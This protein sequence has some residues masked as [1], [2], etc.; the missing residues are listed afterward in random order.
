MTE[1][2]DLSLFV[3][4][5]ADGISHM[6]LAVEGVGCA[7]CIRKIENGL[8]ELPG[9]TEARL[10]FTNRRLAVGWRDKA[11]DAAEVI[12]ALDRI[13]YRAHPFEAGRAESDEARQAR[14]L[15]RCLAVAGFAAMNIMLLSVAVWSGSS[16]MTPETRDFFHWLSALIALPAAAY[17]GQPFFRSAGM[18]CATGSANMDVP[19][20]L[21]VLLALGMSVIETINHAQ[22]AYFDSAIM[23][24]FF[25][26]C[27][28]YLDHAMRRKTRAVAGNLAALKAEVAHRF[29]ENGEIVIV[30]VAALK[31]GDRLLVRP[32]ERMAADGIVD[33]R[34]FR[35]RREPRDRRNRTTAGRRRRRI[36]AGS[37]NF[38]GALTVRVT[39]AGSDTLIDE[40][41]RLL[42]K[43]V[44]VKSRYLR[45]ADRV[46]RLCAGRARHAALTAAGWMLAGASVHDAV[47]TAIAVLIITC[48]CALALAIPAVQVVASGALFRAGLFSTR[49]CLRA[50]GQGRHVVFDKT[51][52]LTLPEPRVDNAAEIDPDC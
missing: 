2:R 42:E 23:L 45:L 38:S 37:L 13:G 41:E 44:A 11:L 33:Q 19:I 22:H 14:W 10:N 49:R 21:G 35:N 29:E 36:H 16:D 31:A 24:L 26:L 9:V 40:V 25:L 28:R 43:A 27:G 50:A 15:M 51:G 4:R 8:K 20:S 12:D 32:G 47:I 39:A 3:K 6:D 17:A 46:A 30:P 7:G 34:C 18:R 5:D 48:P 52:T 1:T